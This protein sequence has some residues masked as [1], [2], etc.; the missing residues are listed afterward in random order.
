MSDGL[1]VDRGRVTR[2][3]IDRPERRNALTLSVLTRMADEVERLADDETCAVLVLRGSGGSFCAGADLGSADAM[4]DPATTGAVL[5]AANRFV[6]ALVAAPQVVVAEVTGPA[7]GYGVAMALAADVVLARDD[8]YFQLTF[9]R[10]GL[11]PDGGATT[12]VAASA[13]RHVALRMALLGSAVRADEAEAR[14]LATEVVPS[15]DFDRRC[16]EVAAQLAAGSRLATAATKRAVAAAT[17]ERL[18]GVLDL[19]QLEQTV[20]LGQPEFE[21]GVRAF[22]Q[23]RAPS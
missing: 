7:A 5:A 11:M 23:G 22:L 9:S 3:T 8:A 1:V 10:I 20:L 17:L 16:H 14:G 12:F 19:E 18:D 21:A 13:G 2:L 4:V 6:R 15:G